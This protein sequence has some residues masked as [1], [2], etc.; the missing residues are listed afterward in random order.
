MNEKTILIVDDEPNVLN[1]LKRLL[2]PRGYKVLT[3]EGGS[4]ALELLSANSDICIVLTDYQM[5]LITGVD[6]LFEVRRYFPEVGGIILSGQAD[7]STVINAFNSGA[8]YKFLE[9]PWDNDQLLDVIAD[10]FHIV[11]GYKR[12]N[13]S[14]ES[15]RFMSQDEPDWML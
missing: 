4:E 3:A 15:G 12:R 1:S 5:P 11:Q 2:N 9:K 13:A 6:L 14:V 7:L 8:I 10:T